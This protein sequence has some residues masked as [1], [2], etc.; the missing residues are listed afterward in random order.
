[1]QTQARCRKLEV[2]DV[3]FSACGKAAEAAHPGKEP[4]H[5][6]V[7]SV[8]A[9]FTS[10]LYRPPASAPIGRNQFD[11]VFGV[12]LSSSGQSRRPCRR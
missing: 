6:P 11:A 10:V 9:Q 4:L 3:V 1:M 12:E 7:Y 5:F 2:F 8:A